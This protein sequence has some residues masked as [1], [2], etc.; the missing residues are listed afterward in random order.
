MVKVRSYIYSN[1][2][3]I[4]QVG[5]QRFIIDRKRRVNR[6]IYSKVMVSFDRTRLTLLIFF[7]LQLGE[8]K[9][10]YRSIRRKFFLLSEKI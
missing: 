1:P 2:M 6:E 8:K 9:K 5:I 10:I 4:F 3:H 7:N